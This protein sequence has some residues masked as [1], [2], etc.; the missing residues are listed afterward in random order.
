MKNFGV[1]LHKRGK[2]RE[3]ETHFRSALDGAES[4][5]PENEVHP[6]VWQCTVHYA[7]LLKDLGRFEEAIRLCKKALE[8]QRRT[9]GNEHPDVK[10]SVKILGWITDAAK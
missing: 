3:A 7:N 6:C 10:E 4:N 2:L 9:L 5:K 1:F 8:A